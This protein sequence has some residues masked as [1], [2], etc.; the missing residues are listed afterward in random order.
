MGKSAKNKRYRDLLLDIASKDQINAIAECIDNVLHG[1]VPLSGKDI[2]RL[3]R[4]KGPMRNVCDHQV[5]VQIKKE[6]LK[7]SGGFLSF[8]IPLALSVIGP[9][10]KGLSGK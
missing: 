7:Q 8:L 10:V 4:Y 2:A 1:A 9:L 5:P 6:I 3:K